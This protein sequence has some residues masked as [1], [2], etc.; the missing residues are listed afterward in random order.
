MFNT[1]G[2]EQV[3]NKYIFPVV[4]VYHGSLIGV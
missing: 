3:F 2:P 4:L 1:C